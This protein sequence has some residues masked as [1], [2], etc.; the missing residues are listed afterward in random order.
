MPSD[1]PTAPANVW[2]SSPDTA[3]EGLPHPPGTRQWVCRSWIPF[4]PWGADVS[5][6]DES[7][8]FSRGRKRQRAPVWVPAL[9]ALFVSAAVTLGLN[10]V[11]VPSGVGWRKLV[12]E[13]ETTVHGLNIPQKIHFPSTFTKPPSLLIEPTKQGDWFWRIEELT[14]S[15]FVIANTTVNAQ[16]K[17]PVHL[18]IKWKAQGSRW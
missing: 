14:E 4:S 6:F 7:D 15:Y 2:Q 16:S 13:G 10:F 9:V 18:Q 1:Q 12:H 3:R 5:A 8:A 11:L 17:E